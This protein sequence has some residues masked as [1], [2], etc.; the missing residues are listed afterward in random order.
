MDPDSSL[1]RMERT[2]WTVWGYITG[3]V[4]RF[5]RS[6][7]VEIVG[8]DPNS[9]QKST[10]N[11]E[12]PNQQADTSEGDVDEERPRA[13]VSV[14]SLS[15]PVVA[16]E[17]C[18]T[19]TDL[20]PVEESKQLRGG[21]ENKEYK[22]G[23]GMRE[24]QVGQTGN[25]DAGLLLAEEAKA[26]EDAPVRTEIGKFSASEHGGIPENEEEH[27]NARLGGF[28]DGATKEGGEKS[29][30]EG[31]AERES[32]SAV[33]LD[34]DHQKLDESMTEI[35]VTEDNREEDVEDLEAEDSEVELSTGL[36]PEEEENLL[37]GE[38]AVQR[39]D[40]APV[41]TR[42]EA[43]QREGALQLVSENQNESDKAPE[44]VENQVLVCDKL[45]DVSNEELTVTEEELEGENYGTENARVWV[46][47]TEEDAEDSEVELS[48]GLSPEEEENLLKGEAAVQ[49]GDAAPVVT[50]EEAE[51]CEGALQLVSENQNESDKATKQVENQVLV[52]DKLSD[53]SNEELTVT[54]E[55]LKGEN[56]GTENTRVWV[57][58]AEE[59]AEDSE[60]ELS[61]GLSPEE[62]KNLLKGEA[63][64]QRGDAAPVVTR[65]EAEQCEGALQLVSEN[66]NES[67]KATKQ[68][69][70]QVLV[71]DKLSD[72][73]NEELTVTEEEL[74]GENYGTENA[75]VWVAI[76][77][78]D[79]EDSEVELSTGL[80]PEE[81]ENL[82]KGEAAVQR[83]DAAPV[84]TREEAEQCEGALQLVS[85]N[86][87]ESD[88]ATKQV[89]NQVLVCDKLSDVSNE[90]L[91]VTEEELKGE[92]NGTENTR[93]WVAIAEEDAE[94]SEVELSTGL[95]P[96]EE[97]NLLKG[98][99][100]VQ[101]GDAAPVVT[102]EEAE[103]CEG[104][105][106]LVSENQNESDKATK[107]VENQVLVC[108]KLSDVSNEEL[109]VTEEELRGENYGTENARVWVA[110]A[111]EDAED[112][113]VEL[114]TGLSPEEEENLLKG[115]AAVQRGDAAPVVTREEAEQCE[116]ALQLV[117]E[118]Q[119]ESDKA[120]KQV[121]N[122]VL[123]C[124]KLS[125]VSNEELTVTEEEL[126]GENYGTE[127]ARVWV[128]I[129]EE[130]IAE[131][132]NNPT[133]YE[134]SEQ[135]RYSITV[136]EGKQAENVLTKLVRCSEE[137]VENTWLQTTK[138]TDTKEDMVVTDVRTTVES[139]VNTEEISV[140]ENFVDKDQFEEE[141]LSDEVNNKGNCMEKICT[142]T[143]VTVNPEGET[144]EEI[145]RE[146]KNIPLPLIEGQVVESQKQNSQACEETQGGVPEYDNELG[147]DENATQ[148]F[149]EAGNCEEI[150]ITQ[151]PEEVENEDKDTLKNSSTVAD[152]LLERE[153]LEERQDS[154]EDR[155][156]C[157]DLAVD[158][159]RGKEHLGHETEKPSVTVES[160]SLFEKEQVNLLDDSMKTEIK[161][162]DKEFETR[163]GS[164]DEAD[165]ITEDLQNETE[166]AEFGKDEDSKETAG[167][168]YETC[169]AVAADEG[170]GF[171]DKTLTFFDAEVEKMP[172]TSFCLESVYATHTEQ[173]GNRS[174]CL[175][176]RNSE[177]EHSVE[178]ETKLLDDGTVEI[179]DVGIDSEDYADEEEEDDQTQEG[180]E[181]VHLQVAGM[182]AELIIGQTDKGNTKS[183]LS[184]SLNTQE[185]NNQSPDKA[186]EMMKDIKIRND[187]ELKTKDSPVMSAE[188]TE[189]HVTQSEESYTE[190]TGSSV[191]EHPDV[192]DED[193]LDLWIEAA[194]SE[195]T[196]EVK[197]QQEGSE[198]EPQEDTTVD[199]LN[200]E[201]GEIASEE[202]LTESNSGESERV[203]D[204]ET[205]SLSLESGYVDQ[206]FSET[207]VLKSTNSGSIGST[208]DM[209]AT[210]P[211]SATFSAHSAPDSESQDALMDET[212]ET[213]DSYLTEEGTI[214]ETGSYP[215]S[216]L[217]LPEA[218]HLDQESDKS[219]ENRDEESIETEAG[220]TAWKDTEAADDGTLIKMSPLF[221]VKSP[222]AEDEP[223]E[224][225]VCDSSD[226][227][228]LNA[229]GQGRDDSEDFLEEGILPP[230]P[231]SQSEPW[232]ESEERLFSLDEPQR[233]W[234]EDVTESLPGLSRAEV[235]E[236]QSAMCEE[237]NEVDAPVLDFTVQR[238]RI[239][240]KN[241]RI[242]PPTN[243]RSLL[244]MPS[245]DPSPSSRGPVKV[246][247]GVPLGG[248]GIG[249]KLPGLGAGFPVLKK[250]QR[251]VR[252]E[253][254]H[255]THSQ[256]PEKKTEERSDTLKEEEAP[257]KP[258]WMPRGHPGFGNPLM[259]ELKT[260]LKKAPKD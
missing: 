239:A 78:E 54:E 33:I 235:A 231:D 96:E 243:P 20:V 92:N 85:E 39:G 35:Q 178:T 149:L 210:M 36:S 161:H 202:K 189:K 174:P 108:D 185:T 45:S 163:V 133:I 123:V 94:D 114:S 207:D 164:A 111:E 208:H 25:D 103:Q 68:V 77:E 246:L 169:R 250:T 198:P 110:I 112:S 150:Q 15:P 162:L 27:A 212:A 225:T 59:D 124:D 99:A 8:N 238:S 256:E 62:E 81:E 16:W 254:S 91:T 134:E 64:V 22:N 229:P 9:S 236:K 141:R 6:Q 144:E 142:S 154:T 226:E 125:D 224:V 220:M 211:G 147:P 214:S 60:V 158:Q 183:E 55:E 21:S 72:V 19:D 215:D 137:A 10:V 206:S 113:E 203:S 230:E 57:A 240:V 234:S 140:D 74:R 253:D 138:F 86:Q 258:K 76:A 107:Q 82:L 181:I 151:L 213:V 2:M 196:H 41:V 7:P 218:N 148:W 204:M 249:I 145:S 159:H 97:K 132:T 17:N 116:G 251:V 186:S 126:R 66:Q 11:I 170:V 37:K 260:K 177:F 242:R 252:D 52:C 129:A 87:N 13:T 88:K 75:R 101:R 247:A 95:S 65:E 31:V 47:I 216:A 237:Q 84:V 194:M 51:Q 14:R 50:R 182:A 42:E 80:S 179:Q 248:L 38:A 232:I 79:A 44:Q 175:P 93:V 24:E 121:E 100:A 195:D 30:E 130:D 143:L 69:E 102:R 40:A 29:D 71:C 209:L 200:K 43:E 4:T 197:Q 70:N 245:V 104:A 89:E 1:S 165:K 56:N 259:S 122:Q 223:L 109:T 166:V 105:L 106:Q 53:V 67:D 98:E 222:K 199:L 139:D 5:L 153:C 172:E 127:N 49:R 117:S 48:T 90:E 167:D 12:P 61:T 83:G 156:C 23:Q 160:E 120:T 187:D 244:H 73:S 18:T 205:S 173:N 155:N 135:E 32:V 168:G 152:Y 58:I 119:N 3:T 219:H 192:I 188:E 255:E 157:I 201:P 118:N 26:N 128:A 228:K 241:P 136:T 146:F 233:R 221:Q 115:E 63:A 190:G 34:D 28:T 227:I 257:P 180:N 217:S 184:P 131:A 171:A 176:E 46:A 193:I 191:R